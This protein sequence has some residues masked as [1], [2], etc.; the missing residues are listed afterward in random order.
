MEGEVTAYLQIRIAGQ[1]T[2]GTHGSSIEVCGNEQFYLGRDTE[3][4]R[5][6]WYEDLT[7]SRVHLRIHCILYDED[8]DSTIAPFLYATDLS[9]NG[10]YLK[11]KNSECTASQGPGIL[12]GRNGTFL[13]EDGDEISISDTVTL[14]YRARRSLKPMSLTTTQEKERQTFASRFLIT[15]R[16]LGEG[17]YG[18]VLV[19]IKQDTQRQLACKIIRIDK[20]YNNIAVQNLRLPTGGQQ[21]RERQ[22]KNRWPTRVTSCFREFDILKDLTHPNVIALEKVFWSP[23]TIY[24]FL[25][26]ATGGDLFS[27]INFKGGKLDGTQAATVV[28]QIL[29]GVEYLHG[30]GIAHRDLKPDNIL[31]T[32][33]EED[34]RV[35]ISDFGAARFLPGAKP[36]SSQSKKYQRMFSVVGTFEY[37]APEIYR[38]N[39]AIPSDGGYS[40]SVDMWSIGSITA[41]LLTGEALFVD[42]SHP[43]YH[44]N[45][46][47]VIVGLAAVCDLRVLDEDHHPYWGV[48]GDLPKHFIKNL[49][50]LKEEDRMTASI[51]LVH[52]WFSSYAEDTKKVYAR[53]IAAWK[54]RKKNIQL[55]ERIISPLPAAGMSNKTSSYVT[56]SR[57]FG[58]ASSQFRRPNTPL[59]SI[60]EDHESAQ[61]ASQVKLSSSKDKAPT[62]HLQSGGQLI[63]REL[64]P[65]QASVILE[66]S[67]HQISL[68]KLAAPGMNVD[69]MDD[70]EDSECSGESLNRAT[71]NY[72]QRRDFI[73]RLQNPEY[74]S[75]HGLVQV[76]QT[77]L[78]EYVDYEERRDKHTVDEVYYQQ[79]EAQDPE[80]DSVLVQETPPELMQ[81]RERAYDQALPA[82]KRRFGIDSSG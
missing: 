62:P 3:L 41:I 56:T 33:F 61:C 23:N 73:R 75:E 7:I 72:S 12:M 9:A 68:V 24:I 37:T 77:P 27:F 51:A 17:G 74:Q 81:K 42:R 66:S 15:G 14:I 65:S 76:P 46:K 39:R 79:Q 34:A 52:P 21:E 30:Q 59:P 64:Q 60:I 40:K 38:L 47:D 4:C 50:V 36:S 22:T 45:P 29:K 10:T 2:Y 31:M 5:Y 6:A 44:T 18:K 63:H 19:G 8:P 58:D 25:E 49:L 16:L 67:G 43:E 70:G 69:D 55:V 80:N 48:V 26:L 82:Y 57:H 35:V 20:L 28:H 71:N 32:S 53:T 78:E 54:P 11:K 13:L 1:D